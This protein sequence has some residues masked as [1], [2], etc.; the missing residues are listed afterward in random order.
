MEEEKVFNSS[1]TWLK[2]GKLSTSMGRSTVS[3]LAIYVDTKGR[4]L[5]RGAFG[6]QFLCFTA[7]TFIA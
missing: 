1:S 5:Y 6:T 3:K 4:C 2:L 7:V